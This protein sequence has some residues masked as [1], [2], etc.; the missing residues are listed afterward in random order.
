MRKYVRFMVGLHKFF[1]SRLEPHEAI[2]RARELLRKRIEKREENFLTIVRKGVFGYHRSPYIRLLRARN[3]GYEDIRRWTENEGVEYTLQRLLQEGVYFT[4]DEFKGKAPVERDGTRFTCRE[5]QFDNPFLS[6]AYE[7]RSGATR[8]VGTRV[9]IDFDYLVQRSLYDAFL[10]DAHGAL[11]APIANWFPLFPGAPGI[12]SS[13]RF[14]HIGN[15]PRRWFS[16]VDRAQVKVNWEKRWGTELIFRAARL[17]KV[18]LARAEYASLNYA[19]QVAKW[20]DSALQEH[21]HCVVYTFATS[22]VRVC[23]AAQEAGLNVRGARFFV[24]GETLTAQKKRE[25]EAAGARAVPVYGISEA[26]VIAAGCGEE[27]TED[28]CDDCHLYKDTMAVISHPHQVPHFDCLVNSFLFTTL[29]YESP[30]L[31][32]NV[33]MGDYGNVSTCKGACGFS[34][35][36]FDTHLS[37]IRS[38]EKLTGEGVTF[39]DTDFIRILEHDLPARFGGRST[40]YQLVEEED[41][42]GLNRYRLLVSPRVGEVNE[43]KVVGTFIELL[44]SAQQSPESWAQSGSEMWS[45]ARTIRIKREFPLST[46]SGKILPFHIA[47]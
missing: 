37:A 16:Q 11:T 44:K 47:K 8:S 31:L 25:I 5:S 2:E 39:V 18:P 1:N 45:Q 6:T 30:K 19:H 35:L 15:P 4:V 43:S 23:M 3:I 10:L 9:R 33:G 22:A 27:T 17:Y 46:P 26:G 32:L 40:D 7:V 24:T 34:Q 41:A 13:L 42:K 28:G 38:Y 20:V 14:T 36:G 12:N 21:D 29:L